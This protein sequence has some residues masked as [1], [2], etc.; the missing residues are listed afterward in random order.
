MKAEMK[1][2]SESKKIECDTNTKLLSYY[3]RPAIRNASMCYFSFEVRVS[4]VKKLD[5]NIKLYQTMSLIQ[6]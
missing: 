6:N 5:V 2:K 4:I 1:G 3:D